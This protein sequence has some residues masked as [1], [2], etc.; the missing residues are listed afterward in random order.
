LENIAV[1]RKVKIQADQASSESA[2]VTLWQYPDSQYVWEV[3]SMMELGVLELIT[4]D[5]EV[6][7]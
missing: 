5:G 2:E 7:Q 6:W 1:L 4:M 3:M